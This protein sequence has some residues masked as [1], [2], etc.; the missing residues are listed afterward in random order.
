[1]SLLYAPESPYAQERSQWEAQYSECGPPRRPYVKY[2][3]P[4]ML[5]KAGRIASGSPDIVE[6]HIAESEVQALN[7]KSR[8]F[9]ETPTEALELLHADDFTVAELAAERNFHERRMSAQAQA[10]AAAVDASTGSHV[11]S[12]PETPIQP[13]QKSG[14]KPQM[15]AVAAG[16]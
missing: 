5:H 10:E 3:Y 1:M 4:M 7:L 9:R 8:G 16:A 11:A 13:K 12:I 14:P 15:A 6:T 2:E